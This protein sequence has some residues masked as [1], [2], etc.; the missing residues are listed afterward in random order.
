MIDWLTADSALMP[1]FDG[2]IE[3]A[4]NTLLSSG[5]AFAIGLALGVVVLAL[6]VAGGPL[7][8]VAVIVYVSAMRGTPLLVQLL[9]AYY[10]LPSLLGISIS[11]L[12]A[13]VLALALNTTAY[14]SEILRAALST[15]PAG[16]T[17]AAR[18]LG[19]RP[20]QCWLHVLLPQMF[21]RALPPLTNEF[22]VLLKASS[23]LS[24][25]AVSELATVARNATLQS[26]LPLQVFAATA[27]VY[28][29]MLWCASTISRSVERRFARLLPNVH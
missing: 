25:I 1:F 18:A 17:A 5:A 3:G 24:L 28:F 14:V 7:G 22:T 26:D 11:P 8:R 6:R 27:A 29:L 12:A 16:Q 15:I 19:M 20:W 2:L 4:G 21:H 9:I 13:G 23:L 10:V